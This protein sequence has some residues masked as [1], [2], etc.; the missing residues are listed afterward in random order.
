M[1]V[2]GEAEG[3]KTVVI[4]MCMIAIYSSVRMCM[5]IRFR[6]S[7]DIDPTGVCDT[8]YFCLQSADW[9]LQQRHL[10]TAL[11]ETGHIRMS[12]FRSL[13]VI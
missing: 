7:S 4:C 2:A 3:C 6:P 5:S 11:L 12:A 10:S 1:R 9:Q 8:P 13:E